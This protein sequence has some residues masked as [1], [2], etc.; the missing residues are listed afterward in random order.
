MLKYR[1]F[2]PV[3]AQVQTFTDCVSRIPDKTKLCVLNNFINP[4]IEEKCRQ[5]EAEGAEVQRFPWNPG[6]APSFNFAMKKLDRHSLDLD[7]VVL[8][9]PSCLFNRSVDD[10]IERLDQEEAKEKRYYYNA[11]ANLLS[12][13]HCIAFTKRMYEEF[14]L[15]DENLQPYGYDDQDT[16]YRFKLMGVMTT[17]LYGIPRTSQNLGAGI[18]SD[19]RLTLHFQMSAGFQQEYFIRK[20]GGVFTQETF[21]KPFNNPFL[22]HRDWTLE[23]HRIQKLLV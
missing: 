19:P 11:Q 17:M 3:T 4:Q 2:V 12:D 9:S 23:T 5:L 14:G 22:T 8:L 21:T 6:V 16:Q 13:M 20:W 15:W 1:I 10:F 18:G 7:I